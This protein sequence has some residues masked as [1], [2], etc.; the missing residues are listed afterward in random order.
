MRALAV[1]DFGGPD[2]LELREVPAP[3]P[4]PGQVQVRVAASSVN[5]IDLSTRS[6]ALVEAGLVAPR[7]VL[8]IGW[9]VAGEVS[10]TGPGVRAFSAGQRVVGLRDLLFAFPGAHAE[11][12]LLDEGALAPSPGSWSTIEAATLPLNVLTADRALALCGLEAGSTLLVTGALGGVGG[13]VLELT[14]GL[15]VSV[16]ALGGS[17]DADV[18]A[19]LGAKRFLT[20]TAN[21]GAA[22]RELVPGG[23][24]AVIDCARLGIQAH[25]ALR[26]GGTFVSLVRPFAPPPIR[27]T[28]V[29]VVEVHAD[30]ARLR[31]LAA[32]AEQG[33][34]TPRVAATYPIE[35][36]SEAHARL[37]AGGLR[38]RVVL[39]L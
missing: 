32:I 18:A 31:E 36:A 11:Y 16:I 10:A 33:H 25:E 27:A 37:E 28:N 5:P 15:D 26:G 19:Q 13:F 6:G 14:R 24:D 8:G 20:R 2:V 21:V 35:Q 34:L 12:V 9:D 3:S 29:V 7:P 39:T 17:G 23:V 4:G 30:G 38:G 22:V 1:A